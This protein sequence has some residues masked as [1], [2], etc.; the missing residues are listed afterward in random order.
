MASAEVG[1]KLAAGEAV[2]VV[3]VVRARWCRN[4]VE[5]ARPSSRSPTRGLQSTP[6][7]SSLRAIH[8]KV[9]HRLHERGRLHDFGGGEKMGE[10]FLIFLGRDQLAL[11]PNVRTH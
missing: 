7:R 4:K 9:I 1:I 5:L 10:D 11:I 6:D 8:G 3:A 2:V